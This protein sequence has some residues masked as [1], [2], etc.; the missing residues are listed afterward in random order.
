MKVS[1]GAFIVGGC[2][3]RS[4][5]HVW[6]LQ[7][8]AFLV[9]SGTFVEGGPTFAGFDYMHT[10]D[11]H[12]GRCQWLQ[13]Q[14][15]DA[16]LDWAISVDSDSSFSGDELLSAMKW[17]TGNVAIGVVPMLIGGTQELN[18]NH[19]GRDSECRTR[20]DVLRT[21]FRHDESVEISSGGF[22]VAVFNL[23]WFRRWWP[24]P[25]PEVDNNGAN[26]V[27]KRTDATLTEAE[28]HAAVLAVGEDIAFCQAVRRRRGHIRALRVTS[29]HVSLIPHA[30][31]LRWS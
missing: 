18:V 23:R 1:S 22:G 26:C 10:S 8:V 2:V 9:R 30:P 5:V 3:Y 4:M 13:R 27:C 6:H 15:D 11:L 31:E 17:V 25:L 24:K 19:M 16:Q 14:I 12:R 28:P 29:S 21:I 20:P 7:S